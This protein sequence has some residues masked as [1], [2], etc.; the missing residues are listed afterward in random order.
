MEG[1]AYLLDTHVL[2]WLS[3][4]KKLVPADI[5]A[6]LRNP[7]NILF[8]SS[9][10]LWEIAI[11]QNLG[12]LTA[13]MDMSSVLQSHRMQELPVTSQYVEIIRT[14]PLHHRDPFDRMLVAQAQMEGLTLISADQRMRRYDVRVLWA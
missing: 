8:V 13:S 6:R 10:S 14:L 3:S 7:E 2:I 9:A 11:K 12:K 5:L 4:D 1:H